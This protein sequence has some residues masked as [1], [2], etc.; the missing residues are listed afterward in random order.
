LTDDLDAWMERRHVVRDVPTSEPDW[1]PP[2]SESVEPSRA[3]GDRGPRPA[4]S[5]RG[6]S[7]AA[8]VIAVV[9]GGGLATRWAIAVG[10]PLPVG[11]VD[12]DGGVV[13]VRS[14]DGRE[15]W[16][17]SP[18]PPIA[19][20][21][22]GTVWS[23]VADLD[24]EPGEEVVIAPPALPEQ[25]DVL[26]LLSNRG[27][28]RWRHSF[29][30]T[31]TFGGT[32]FGPP[33]RT[34]G[35]TA[36]EV[37][38]ETRIAWALHHQTWDPGIVAIFDAGGAVLGRFVHPGW[39]TS[40]HAPPGGKALL[41]VGVTNAYTALSLVVIDPRAANG[42]PPPVADARSRCADC[43]GGRPLLWL[44]L[45]RPDAAVAA[46]PENLTPGGL[47]PRLHALPGGDFELRMSFEHG[48]SAPE[49]IYTLSPDFVV[50]DARTSDSYWDW[51]RRLERA[52]ALHHSAAD[53]PERRGLRIRAW[54]PEGGWR[55]AS[56]TRR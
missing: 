49:V 56:V 19:A 4:G 44:V 34:A 21:I 37:D 41:A 42:S 32:A 16:R 2:A 43:P 31:F 20:R 51:H 36:L 26:Y 50:R 9:V 45:S 38:G 28:E 55:D 48:P 11:A 30:E 54:T 12:A 25:P 23:V 52:G 13:V 46:S 1:D 17:F 33:W 5:A 7:A 22:A 29:D 3:P 15:A 6:W 53:C 24:E 40:L 39:I 27:R 14:T 47:V 35:V 8:V 10:R 18:A